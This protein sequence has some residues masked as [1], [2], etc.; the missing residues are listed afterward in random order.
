MEDLFN[1]IQTFLGD[2]QFASGGLAV[3]VM[4]SSAYLLRSVPRR[5]YGFIKRRVVIQFE[6][7]DTDPAYGWFAEWLSEQPCA[8]TSRRISVLSRTGNIGTHPIEPGA[9]GRPEL[10]F[11]PAPGFHLIKYQGRRFLIDRDRKDASG[12]DNA[13]SWKLFEKFYIYGFAWDRDV[14]AAMLHEARDNAIPLAENTIELNV[15]CRDY[16][17]RVRAMTGRPINSVVTAND[18]ASRV[19]EDIRAFRESRDWYAERGVPWRRGVLLYGPPGNGKTSLIRAVATELRMSVGVINL[20]DTTINDSSLASLFNSAGDNTLIVLEDIDCV[21]DG[22][23]AK[24]AS[25]KLSFAGL[26]N[27]LDGVAS[28]DGR[29]VVMTTNH[30]DKLD[31]ALIRPGRCDLRVYMGNASAEQA[32]SLYR[33]FFA[34]CNDADAE[35]FGRDVAD[36]DVSMATVQGHLLAHK[37][38]PKKAAM[39]SRGRKLVAA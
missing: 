24:E 9:Q 5:V 25:D 13:S 26:L 3:L 21:F 19:L 39:F 16:W 18:T 30:I 15:A 29:V 28:M 11:V 35:A 2:N 32:E 38:S 17:Q 14:I 1:W 34:D 31:N 20:S 23:D 7:L 10:R 4:S 12:G 36:A 33:R 37:D 8:T 22:R 6:I 27:A